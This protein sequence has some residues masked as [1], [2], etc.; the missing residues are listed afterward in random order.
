ML[1]TATR[2]GRARAQVTVNYTMDDWQRWCRMVDP[3]QTL[4]HHRP[5][6]PGAA[7]C[8]AE[9]AA[10]QAD[11]A[12]ASPPQ[13]PAGAPCPGA[14][15]HDAIAGTGGLSGTTGRA[16]EHAALSA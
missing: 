7:A 11:A 4:M 1:S 15:A 5:P 13:R 14:P 9:A 2:A 6:V 3:A 12:A 8:A 10:A 16:A